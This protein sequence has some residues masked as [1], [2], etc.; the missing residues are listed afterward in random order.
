MAGRI[1]L[2]SAVRPW[3]RVRLPAVDRVSVALGAVF[4]VGA[5]FYLWTAGTSYPLTLSG[6]YPSNPYNLLAGAFLHLHLSVGRPPTGLLELANPY[7]P[8]ANSTF[9]LHP[10]DIHDFALYHGRLYLT[11][12]PAPLVVLLPLHL[13]G[14]E[15]ST[16]LTAAVF[17]LAGLGFALATLRVVVAQLGGVTLWVCVVG[18]LTLALASAVPFIL[19][20]PEVYEEAIA[21]GFCFVMAGVWLAASALLAGRATL[22]RMALMS[23]CFG[24]TVGSRPP[25]G[26][27]AAAVMVP[28]YLALRGTRPRRELAAALLAPLG[29]CLALL[30][31]YNYARYGNPLEVGQH[32]QLAGIDQHAAHFGALGYL[33]PGAWFYLAAPPRLSILFPFLQLAP[34][35]VSYPG[36]LP[37]VYA[38][39]ELTGGLLPMVPILIFLV[40]L[41]WIWRRRPAWLGALGAP[42]LIL[43]GAGL[44]VMAFLSYE[45]FATTERYEVDFA[46]LLLLGALAAWL[47]LSARLRGRS[48][49]AVRVGGGLLAA[50]GCLAGLAISF[51][52]YADLLVVNHPGT[53]AKLESV[54]APV[55]EAL[56]A[57]SGGPVLAEVGARRIFRSGPVGL[58]SL[59]SPVRAFGVSVGEQSTLTIVSPDSRSADL[60]TRLVPGVATSTGASASHIPARVLVRG[61]GGAGATYAVPPEGA[62][63]RIPLALAGGVNRLTLT[64]LA[65]PPGAGGPVPPASAQMVVVASLSIAPPA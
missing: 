58:T 35:P 14:L 2:Q 20:R 54:T 29:V 7:D 51:T 8:V 59:E 21:A 64:P 10:R 45:F 53:W 56:A 43:A 27:A 61:L 44:A 22:R 12:G 19:R 9:Q 36:S 48:R 33:A 46:G 31:A 13:L 23:L 16:S 24:L 25:L 3:A 49:L 6:G 40:A 26:L 55:S 34:P 30:A 52:G 41:P 39:F 5:V 63:T 47:A 62:I 42:L 4:V 57:L 65:T 60:V 11:W 17:A 50:W 1:H 18:A 38:A 15:P 37:A 32:Y 28:V